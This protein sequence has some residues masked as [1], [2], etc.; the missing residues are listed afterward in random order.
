MNKIGSQEHAN[1]IVGGSGLTTDDDEA[2]LVA[3]RILASRLRNPG[4]AFSSP[5][6]VKNFAVLQL[7]E[8]EHEV[9]GVIW[10]D[11]QNRLMKYA[12]LVYGTISQAAVYPREV[13]KAGLAINAAAAIFIHN[14]PSG[15]PQPSRA[16]EVLTNNLK[17]ALAL[18]DIRVLDH[19]VVAHTTGV[20]FAEMGL[21]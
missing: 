10:L 9:F 18:V 7:T 19:I 3:L 16:D 15:T 6:D 2:I 20:S 21:L 4:G 1:Y 8:R 14:H 12:E 17:D 11:A 13:V 5:S